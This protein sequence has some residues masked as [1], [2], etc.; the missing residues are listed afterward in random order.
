[1][2]NEEDLSP[3]EK[4]LFNT[5]SRQAS[6]NLALESRIVDHLRKEGLIKAASSRIKITLRWAALIVF[7]IGL[8][9]FGAF[10]SSAL[11]EDSYTFILLL[12]N[13]EQMFTEDPSGRFEEYGRWSTE[14][15]KQ[16]ISITGEKLSSSKVTIGTTE[17]TGSIFTGF[18][19]VSVSSE[20]EAVKLAG[21]CPHIKYG[22]AIEIRKIVNQ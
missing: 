21:T 1:M 9:L 16:G 11:K 18:F 7:G 14:I 6:H 10:Y 13:S 5:L 15:Q 22:G 3:K 8:F 2:N 17:N 20:A 19:L 12:S 4:E